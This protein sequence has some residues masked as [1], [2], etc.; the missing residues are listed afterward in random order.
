MMAD[1]QVESIDVE[2]DVELVIEDLAG[3]VDMGSGVGGELHLGVVSNGSVFHAVGEPE[4]LADAIDGVK[5]QHVGVVVVADV[6][7]S[8]VSVDFAARGDQVGGGGSGGDDDGGGARNGRVG[9]AGVGEGGL[10]GEKEKKKD[11]IHG[12]SAEGSR[13]REYES[14]TVSIC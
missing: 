11:L 4:E 10:K 2:A 5:R 13:K 6:E 3:G 14:N 9:C 7:D 8:A 12:E 1:I